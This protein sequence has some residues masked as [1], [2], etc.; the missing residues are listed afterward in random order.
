[1]KASKAMKL[2][3]GK[4]REATTQLQQHVATSGV[5]PHLSHAIFFVYP[6]LSEVFINSTV[7]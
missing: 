1:M 3:S 4:G 7:V 6:T 2:K 5:W